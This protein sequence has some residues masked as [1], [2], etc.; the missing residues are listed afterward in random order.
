MPG[1]GR[2]AMSRPV[3]PRRGRPGS[4]GSA[5]IAVVLDAWRS[6]EG[7]RNAAVRRANDELQQLREAAGADARRLQLLREDL[8]RCQHELRFAREELQQ[9]TDEVVRLRAALDQAGSAAAAQRAAETTTLQRMVEELRRE[10]DRAQAELLHS[11]DR[12]R[13]AEPAQPGLPAH[14]AQLRAEKSDALHQCLRLERENAQLRAEMCAARAQESR[15]QRLSGDSSGVRSPR[16]DHAVLRAD[17]LRA[18]ALR[19]QLLHLR[20]ERDSERLELLR[21]I[22]GSITAEEARRLRETL[23][24]REAELATLRLLRDKQRSG[25]GTVS[26]E[27]YR[28]AERQRQALA[29]SLDQA[30]RERETREAHFRSEQEQHFRVAA[31]LAEVRRAAGDLREQHSR[32][33]EELAAARDEERRTREE[34]NALEDRCEDLRQQLRQREQ[35]KVQT[36]GDRDAALGQL[37]TV[38]AV[39]EQRESDL[40]RAHEE[41]QQLRA[42][43]DRTALACQRADAA[44]AEE[45]QCRA[46]L[47]ARSEEEGRQRERKCD[48]LRQELKEARRAIDD[49]QL[50]IEAHEQEVA[51]LRHDLN[52]QRQQHDQQC[53]LLRR[54]YDE[55]VQQLE[56]RRQQQLDAQQRWEEEH[57][58]ALEEERRRHARQEAELGGQ[59]D[60]ESRRVQDLE[61]ELRELRSFVRDYVEPLQ[62]AAATAKRLGGASG[63]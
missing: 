49:Q 51:A 16:G 4:P 12:A 36:E 43:C 45:R 57:H 8:G 50:R 18:D 54:G 17:V 1:A 15:R 9:K 47:A 37:R 60:R 25:G 38:A 59:L 14:V 48:K 30:L 44:L 24:E 22:E 28:E 41:L 35:E 6:L 40:R 3:S 2:R 20:R 42:D 33:N 23:A 31:E 56:A 34:T 53:E 5:E 27:L 10:R 62:H 26:E 52:V 11:A 21:R 55:Q 39:K 58:T 63:H 32:L 19:E 7:E 46:E 13:S 61:R 29:H